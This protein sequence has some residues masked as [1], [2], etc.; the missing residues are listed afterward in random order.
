MRH[1]VMCPLRSEMNHPPH[2]GGPYTVE[3]DYRADYDT[4]GRVMRFR[5]W[6][7]ALNCV[8]MLHYATV[9]VLW[10]ELR[11]GYPSI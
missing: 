10:S 6:A 5:S 4:P 3:V 2:L 7:A 8:L 1:V 9:R 11:P